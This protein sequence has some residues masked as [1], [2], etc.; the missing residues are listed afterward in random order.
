I[1]EAEGEI[2]RVGIDMA[3]D[4]ARGADIVL[5]VADGSA[6]VDKDDKKVA[7]IV[8]PS[9]EKTALLIVSKSD[10]RQVIDL[11][12]AGKLMPFA[13]AIFVSSVTGDGIAELEDGIADLVFG[14][15]TASRESLLVADVRQKNLLI[16]AESEALE[17]THALRSGEPLDFAE[18]NI[19]AAYDALGEIIGE[20]V[21]EDILDRVFERFCIG[22]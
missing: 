2:E 15:K 18:V 4:A 22:K 7:E 12:E 10:M 14:G 3:A 13:K 20:T 16:R 1:R 11:T 8:A 9:G 21:T 5:F 6:G 19:K 17:A